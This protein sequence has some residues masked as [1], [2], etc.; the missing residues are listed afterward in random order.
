MELGVTHKGSHD[1]LLGNNPT[2]ELE[3]QYSNELR[4]TEETS[5]AFVFLASDDKT[6]PAENSMRYV[7][8]LLK[9]KV[10]C[11]LHMYP[12]GGHGWGWSD[13]YFYKK[14]WTSELL[15]WLEQF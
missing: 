6:V 14:Q 7:N 13:G 9:C 2:A 4:V 11:T 5:R 8:A 1:N 10:P 15:R 3:R 12:T